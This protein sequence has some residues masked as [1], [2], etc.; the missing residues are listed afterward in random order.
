MISRWWGWA[1]AVLMTGSGCGA[2]SGKPNGL[3]VTAATGGSSGLDAS[4]VDASLGGSAGAA[5]TGG[6]AGGPMTTGKVPDASNSSRLCSD[7][8][9]QSVV[10]AYSFEIS[11]DNWAKLDADFHDLKDVLAGTPPQTYYPIVFHYGS[12]T[13]SNA[14]VRLRGKSSWVTTVMSDSNPKMQFDISFD[15]I[16]TSQK[17]HGVSTLHLEI[18]RDDW[19]FLNERIGNNWFREIGLLAPCSNSATVTV[20]GSFYGL[21]VAQDG[22]TKSLLK[23]F[24]PGN[25]T[26]DLFKGGTE[27]QTNTT[28]ANWTRLQALHS[29]SDIATLQTL[30]DLP[31][32]VLEWAAE[33]VVEDADGYYGGSHNYY[34]YDEG[35]AGYV[36]L[37]DHTDSALEWVD[38]FAPSLGVKEHPV[39]WWAGRPLPDP[40]AQDYLLVINDPT[41]RAQYVQAIAT[42]TPK[43]NTQEILGWIDAWTPQI[44]SAVAAD[45]HK[46]ATVDQFNSAI[47]TLK[48]MVQQRP[49]Y[50]QSF[51]ACEAG[52]PTQATDQ[53]GDGVPWCNDCDDSTA[54][55]HPGAAEI[56]GN[57]VDDN[58]NGVV[59]E[60]CPGGMP[61]YPG[62]PDA[63]A[64]ATG[65]VDGGVRG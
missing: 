59:D 11:A 47:A 22:V 10:P 35:N 55:V 4:T 13:V 25:S 12:E 62:Q 24:F 56:C 30:V 9:D 54:S 51:T 38:I 26:G 65:A 19:T 23:E 8:F 41:W 63:G 15:K 31:N 49:V 28:T 61:G 20:N 58:C 57:H 33:A 39:Y 1:A 6:T 48:D 21:Y 43:W 37:L 14:A 53:D 2:S 3:G 42:Q 5:A 40:P 18:A 27:A 64:P 34:V 45:P 16:D 29:A 52:D 46:W 60:N 7:L 36:W 50:L 17:F 44:A 32:T